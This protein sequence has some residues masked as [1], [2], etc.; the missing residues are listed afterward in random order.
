M[1]ES[2][3]RKPKPG[4]MHAAHFNNKY[5]YVIL[6]EIDNTGLMISYLVIG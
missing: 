6:C 1:H 3:L 4:A 2:I 5:Y